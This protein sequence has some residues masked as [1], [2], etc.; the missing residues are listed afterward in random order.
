[1]SKLWKGHGPRHLKDTFQSI[2]LNIWWFPF[3]L[4]CLTAVAVFLPSPRVRPGIA[5][6]ARRRCLKTVVVAMQ[7]TNEWCFFADTRWEVSKLMSVRKSKELA[8]KGNACLRFKTVSS[9]TNNIAVKMTKFSS[10]WTR[11]YLLNDAVH[12]LSQGLKLSERNLRA[13]C[14]SFTVC[15][16]LKTV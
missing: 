9:W 2:L 3:S 5:Q 12:G 15:F 7:W 10:K 4:L 14:Q 16:F 8:W 11:K 1:M 6:G 13:I